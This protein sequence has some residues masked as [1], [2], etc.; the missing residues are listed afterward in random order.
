MLKQNH[1][2][3]RKKLSQPSKPTFVFDVLD[4]ASLSGTFFYNFYAPDEYVVVNP[5]YS[6]DVLKNLNKIPRYISLTWNYASSNVTGLDAGNLIIQN[7]TLINDES[8][9]VAGSEVKI[10]IHDVGIYEYLIG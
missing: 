6:D 2:A 1:W 5:T 8:N 10:V 3:G 4:L 7:P 9:V